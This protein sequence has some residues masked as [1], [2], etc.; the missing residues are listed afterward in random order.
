LD[1]SGD[2]FISPIDVVLIINYINAE[3]AGQ[4]AVAS[5]EGEAPLGGADALLAALA[6]DWLSPS[7]RRRRL[8][9]Q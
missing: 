9:F 4:Q 5:G 2:G 8:S 7:V 1:S 6:G 3:A